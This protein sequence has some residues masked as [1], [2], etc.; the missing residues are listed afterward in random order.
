YEQRLN[1]LLT[2]VSDKISLDRLGIQ[3]NPDTGEYELF[4]EDAPHILFTGAL[5]AFID[6]ASSGGL[7]L[8]FLLFLLVGGQARERK[9]GSLLNEIEHRAQTYILQMVGFSVLTG[10]LV[11][12]ILGILGVPYAFAFGFVA[13]LLNFIP[14]IGPLAATL[15]P[16]PVVLLDAELSLAARILAIVL[17]AGV[18]CTFA[19]IQPRIQGGSQ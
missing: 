13:F 8:I 1:E 9:P 16:L 17:P 6:V 15:L 10:T 18:Q 19:V 3:R 2:E 4:R 12:V 7:V 11:G 5:N 14:T